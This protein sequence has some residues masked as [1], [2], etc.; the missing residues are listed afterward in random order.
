MSQSA[1]PTSWICPYVQQSPYAAYDGN[2]ALYRESYDLRPN[3]FLVY[4][5]HRHGYNDSKD[6]YESSAESCLK[7]SQSM[8]HVAERELKS[9]TTLFTLTN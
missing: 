9:A 4:N 7:D 3:K 8:E 2:G 1:L 5:E 6:V